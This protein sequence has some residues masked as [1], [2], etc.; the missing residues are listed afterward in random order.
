[1]A[2]ALQEG[3]AE[4][5]QRR[6][7]WMVEGLGEYSYEDWLRIL[8]LTS[9]ETKFLRADLIEFFKILRVLRIWTRI[10][11]SGRWRWC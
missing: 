8:G 1:M 6:A 10:D 2:T 9:L 11:F 3:Q 4:K 7:T 5:V